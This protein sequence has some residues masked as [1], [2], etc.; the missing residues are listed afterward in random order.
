MFMFVFDADASSPLL[1][2]SDGLLVLDTRLLFVLDASEELFDADASSPFLAPSLGL[3]VLDPPVEGDVV[4]RYAVDPLFGE[5]CRPF[6]FPAVP[7]LERPGL[8]KL[9][10]PASILVGMFSEDFGFEVILIGTKR[11]VCFAIMLWPCIQA[12]ESV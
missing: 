2:P 7:V 5:P 6:F 1:A 10:A 4:V 11:Q 12:P 3:L 8:Q 9:V